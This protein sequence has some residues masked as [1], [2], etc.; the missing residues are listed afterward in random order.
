[1]VDIVHFCLQMKKLSVKEIK[2]FA[3]SQTAWRIP[4]WNQ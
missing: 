4:H 1:M 3:Q 2:S